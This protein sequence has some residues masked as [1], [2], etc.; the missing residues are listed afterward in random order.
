[1]RFR[2]RNSLIYQTAFLAIICIEHPLIMVRWS[3]R[4]KGRAVAYSKHPLLPKSPTWIAR[5]ENMSEPTVRSVIKHWEEF[6]TV[7]TKKP[8]GRPRILM[9]QQKDRLI[10]AIKHDPKSTIDA[11][12]RVEHIS[13]STVRRIADRHGYHSRICRSKCFVSEGQSEEEGAVGKG[14]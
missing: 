4:T 11:F 12:G 1:M 7:H 8:P 2:I 9:P 10:R 3:P 5:Q 6:R 13:T 14:Q